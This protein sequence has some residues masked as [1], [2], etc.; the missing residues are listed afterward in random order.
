[1]DEVPSKMHSFRA[2]TVVDVVIAGGYVFAYPAKHG[3]DG[4]VKV[5]LTDLV[6][7]D[8][9]SQALLLAYLARSD[10]GRARLPIDCVIAVLEH[11]AARPIPH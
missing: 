3:S 8:P 10:D 7:P 2:G 6:P 4:R 5:P 1:M 11:T 9:V